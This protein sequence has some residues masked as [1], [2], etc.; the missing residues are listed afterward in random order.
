MKQNFSSF[1]QGMLQMTQEELTPF[2][3]TCFSIFDTM[4]GSVLQSNG[5]SDYMMFLEENGVM[6]TEW[7]PIEMIVYLD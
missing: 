7:S 4:R 1:Q 6:Q 5:I 2:S 3:V